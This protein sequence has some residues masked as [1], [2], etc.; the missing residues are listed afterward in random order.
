MP[1]TPAFGAP[2]PLELLIIAAFLLPVVVVGLVFLSLA[3][4]NKNEEAAPEPDERS[5]WRVNRWVLEVLKIVGI[6]GGCFL[7]W[8][9]L[10]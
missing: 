3:M 8:Y 4:R 6:I 10:R 7:A 9:L 2:G 5:L 1:V